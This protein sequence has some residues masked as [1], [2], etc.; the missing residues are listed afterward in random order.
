MKSFNAGSLG[1]KRLD[2]RLRK[3]RSLKTSAQTSPRIALAMAAMTA[4]QAIVERD[5]DTA[6][7][8]TRQTEIDTGV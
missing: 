1:A 7:S 6:D 3:I 8:P 2:V 5:H 4:S